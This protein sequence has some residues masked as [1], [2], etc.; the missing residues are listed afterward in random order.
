MVKAF[1]M[2]VLEYFSAV[3]SKNGYSGGEVRTIQKVVRYLQDDYSTEERP[4]FFLKQFNYWRRHQHEE[5]NL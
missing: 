1:G 2:L 5:R 4:T 3:R